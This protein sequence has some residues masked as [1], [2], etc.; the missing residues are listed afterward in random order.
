VIATRILQVV[1]TALLMV[2]ALA[3]YAVGT[4]D[5]NNCRNSPGDSCER[6]GTCAIQGSDWYQYVTID[7]TDI[8]DT[9][10]WPGLCDMVHVSLVQGDCSP[11]GSRVDVTAYLSDTTYADIPGITGVLACNAP[12]VNDGDLA[13]WGAPDGNINGADLLIAA[14][15]VL[16]LRTAGSLQ[17]AHG[18]MNLDGVIDLADLMLIQQVVLQ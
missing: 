17:V 9:Q 14:Q 13:P 7:K 8:F 3:V 6:S 11:P 16:G 4:E 1:C 18:D 10:G 12:I 5:S 15:L 2:A